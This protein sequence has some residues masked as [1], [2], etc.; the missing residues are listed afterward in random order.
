MSRF[1]R[2]IKIL[3]KIYNFTI[4]VLIMI[5]ISEYSPILAQNRKMYQK[6]LPTKV[7]SFLM[8]IFDLNQTWEEKSLTEKF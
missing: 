2:K 3:Q 7:Q 6:I 4:Y 5:K 8:S 1:V